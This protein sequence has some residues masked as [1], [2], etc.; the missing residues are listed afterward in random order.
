M[1]INLAHLRERSTTGTPIDFAVFDA[2]SNSGTQSDNS[3]LL[4]QLT[5]QARRSGLKVD[6]AAL[7]YQEN[8]RIRFFGS[9]HLVEHLSRSGVPGWTHT[10]NV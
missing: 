7:A 6:Q 8:G 9:K 2:R 4:D 3:R 5:M 1:Q 10:I